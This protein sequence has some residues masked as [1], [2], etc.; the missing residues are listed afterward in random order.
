MRRILIV[1]LFSALIGLMVSPGL[2]ALAQGNDPPSLAAAT[3]GLTLFTQYPA[4][5]VAIGENVTL[6]LILRT[7]ST[8]ETVKLELQ[9][10]PQGWTAMFKGGGR[11]VEAAYVEPENDTKVDLRVDPPKD[12]TAG[13]YNFSVV[14][15]DD[16]GQEV[17]LPIQLT[18]TEKLPP[19]LNF[20]AELPTLRGAPDST[21]RYNA[22]L[23]NE[24]D[25]DLSVNLVADA[26]PGFQ[27]GF[28]LSGQDVTN[29]PLAANETKRLSVEAKAFQDIPA[30]D[31][32]IQVQ[33]QGGEAQAAIDLTAEVTGQQELTVTTPDGRLSGQAYVGQVTPLKLVV[34]NTGS[35][36]AHNVQLSAS[37]PAG[38][39]VEFEPKQLA[40]IPAGKQMEV[41]ANV[42]P[43]DQAIAGDYV[44]SLRA[45]PEDGP[46]KP[47]DFRITVLTSTLWGIVGIGLI[48]VAVVV[49]GLAVMR[50]GRR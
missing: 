24:G 10:L 33:A 13:V 14:A 28:K 37:Q 7:G 11:V 30:G 50:F 8:P 32:P 40:E 4:E 2:P 16:N 3:P 15:R 49:V 21:F 12:V 29:I 25:T 34:Q 26:P 42:Q 9:D 48:A 27:V 19:N 5:E 41:T 39:K 1:T 31:Y 20:S 23:K 35:D 44:I 43:S 17:K 6:N 45:T 47:A 18:V 36:A 46:A 22:T 38:W